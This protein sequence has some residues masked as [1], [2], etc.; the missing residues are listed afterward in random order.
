MNPYEN[1]GTE[2]KLNGPPAN[3][4]T[5]NWELMEALQTVIE[6]PRYSLLDN[7]YKAMILMELENGGEYE[8]VDPLGL[9]P[10]QT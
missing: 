4:Q 5:A 8:P 7:G 2:W 3:E 1:F 6:S 10:S 9:K